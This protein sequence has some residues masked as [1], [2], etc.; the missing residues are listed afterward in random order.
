VNNTAGSGTGA[1]NVVVNAGAI[2]GGNGTVGDTGGG[3]TV[4]VNAGGIVRPGSTLT[5]AGTLTVNSTA[6]TTFASGSILQ[7]N[8]GASPSVGGKLAITGGGTVDLSGLSSTAPMNIFLTGVGGLTINTP[9]S[10]TVIDSGATPFVLPGGGFNSNL[11]SVTANFG[12]ASA[13]TVTNPTA[14][15]LVLGFT[16]V[17]EPASI[18]VIAA[19]AA[20][21]VGLRR[22]FRRPAPGRAS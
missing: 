10:L 22:R 2:L 15:T 12:L 21:A 11:F 14:G 5:D 16:P 4:T 17:P 13:V 9:Y 7:V 19:G 8:V 6:N 18:L 1:G 20:G 3:R